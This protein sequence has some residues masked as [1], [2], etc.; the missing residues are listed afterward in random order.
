[1]RRWTLPLAASLL[2]ASAA[3]GATTWAPDTTRSHLEFTGT[4]SGG[5]F[6]GS[7][8]RF[9]PDITFDP[10]DLAGTEGLIRTVRANML[11]ELGRPYVMVA[12]SKGLTENK[13]ITKYPFRIAMNPVVSTIGWTLPALVSGE[14][15]VSLVLIPALLLRFGIQSPAAARN[16]LSRP[17]LSQGIFLHPL[18]KILPRKT[19]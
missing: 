18:P 7:F 1:M 6:D 13:V 19:G 10:V 2:A 11:D 14:L 3:H 15:L 4:L 5:T 17:C 16:R 9:Q 8:K 12:R